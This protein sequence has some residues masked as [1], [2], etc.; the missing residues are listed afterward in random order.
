MTDPSAP[1]SRPSVHAEVAQSETDRIASQITGPQDH[2]GLATLWRLTMGLGHWW[3]IAVGEP[4]RESPAAADVDG[5]AMLLAF[6]SAERARHFAVQQKMIEPDETL[7]A[8]A[9]TPHEVV[10]GSAGYADALIDGLMFDAHLS[11]YFISCDQ[12]PVLWDAVMVE[13][14][15][16]DPAT[17]E[18]QGGADPLTGR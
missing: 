6:T 4:G 13:A 14:D 9:L 7:S 18:S 10:E 16:G 1:V 3:F 5:K 11:G 12:L 2:V 8:I 15:A 17:A